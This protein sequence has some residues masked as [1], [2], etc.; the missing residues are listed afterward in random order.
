MSGVYFSLEGA[1]VWLQRGADLLP[2]TPL[3]RVLRAIF[4]DGAG[5]AS[6]WTGIALIGG[7]TL[8]LFLLATRRFKWV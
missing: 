1:P 5:L 8:A 2:L 3:V 7:W 4:N 6:E